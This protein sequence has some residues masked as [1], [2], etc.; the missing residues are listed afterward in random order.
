MPSKDTDEERVMHSKSDRIEI[1]T[2]NK[3]DEVIRQLF[4]SVLS[5]YQTGIA[6]SMKGGDFAFDYVFFIT[7]ARKYILKRGGSYIVSP[8]LIK[9]SKK[10]INPVNNYDK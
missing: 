9:K 2:F 8:D 3:A 7:N 6:K 10:A 5:G 4:E 1:L